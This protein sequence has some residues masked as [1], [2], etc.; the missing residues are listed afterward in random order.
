MISNNIL[1][2]ILLQVQKMMSGQ[3]KDIIQI[4]QSC[5]ING[6]PITLMFC[7]MFDEFN[8]LSQ[9]ESDHHSQLAV[10]LVV[11]GLVGSYYQIV[12]FYCNQ[13]NSPFA[14]AI[15]GNFRVPPFFIPLG[16]SDHWHQFHGLQ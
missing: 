9:Y 4:I 1:T 12:Q 16:P 3:E 10:L 11:I 2:S 5:S 13:A 6:I 15:S 14:I 7:L 8:Q